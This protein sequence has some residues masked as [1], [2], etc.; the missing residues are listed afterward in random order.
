MKQF[1]LLCLIVLWLCPLRI[2]AQCDNTLVEKAALESGS[3]AVYLREFK[4]KF[5]GVERGKAIP[6]ARY[7]ILLSR[8]NTYRFNVCN[9]IESEGNIILNLYLKDKLVGSTYDAQTS[10]DL[11][12]FDFVCDKTA[13]YEV[14][15]SFDQ[16]QPG[17]AAGIL[18]LLPSRESLIE[19]VELDVL[20]ALADNPIVIY[21]D[22]N[23]H[24]TIELSINN[25]EVI[26]VEGVNYIIRPQ[27]AGT[28]LLS[29]RVLHKDGSL[30]DFKQKRFAV[31]EL[32]KPYATVRGVKEGKISKQELVQ[33]SRLELWFSEGVKCSYRIVSFTLSDNDDL[34]S[35]IT[36]TSSRLSKS[37]REWI[38]TLP[39]GT[40]LY[41][42]NIRVKTAEH[43]A[44]DVPALEFIIE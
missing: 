2:S 41:V 23:E 10:T 9:S 20:Y 7:P 3:E 39:V 24:A 38:D 13:T 29:I 4:V 44:M 33:G 36:S 40:R 5:D 35:G 32:N 17:C 11:Q 1:S 15:M 30:K 43:V 18:S 12:R 28:A 14:V 6:V 16:G 21:D 34:I 22:E 26:K 31:M 25:G 27:K 37:Q 42:K 19:D 8:N